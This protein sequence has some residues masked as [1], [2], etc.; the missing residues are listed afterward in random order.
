MSERFVRWKHLKGG[1]AGASITPSYD[2][3]ERCQLSTPASW[4]DPSLPVC[5][6]HGMPDEIV[7]SFMKVWKEVFHEPIDYDDAAVKA[8]ELT[9][10]YRVLMKRIPSE[11]RTDDVSTGTSEE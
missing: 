6:M 3:Y 11:P 8:R 1:I 7:R 9:S 10:L 2:L 4:R 5:Y